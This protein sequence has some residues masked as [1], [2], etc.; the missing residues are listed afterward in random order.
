MY[1]LIVGSAFNSLQPWCLVQH[2]MS[3]LVKL[4]VH[5]VFVSSVSL[6]FIFGAACGVHV[7][8]QKQLRLFLFFCSYNLDFAVLLW[9]FTERVSLEFGCNIDQ[10][11]GRHFEHYIFR[12]AL[13]SK[14]VWGPARP[15]P[16]VVALCS[17]MGRLKRRP[18]EQ[19]LLRNFSIYRCDVFIFTARWISLCMLLGTTNNLWRMGAHLEED[20]CVR[21]HHLPNKSCEC[22]QPVMSSHFID[23]SFSWMSVCAVMATHLVFAVLAFS[24]R[25][26]LALR[27][28][29]A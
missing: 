9:I 4:T 29:I 26:L 23:F 19:L 8:R 18:L 21:H 27:V 24:A 5:F 28:G 22:F 2:F 17:R 15:I 14:S 7:K 10:V 20:W 16:W 11:L 6:W 3:D 25:C 12:E 1:L 13:A